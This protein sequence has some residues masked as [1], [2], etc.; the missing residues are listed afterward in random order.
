[1]VLSTL[2]M[3]IVIMGGMG[4][5]GL[6]KTVAGMETIYLDRV[7]PLEQLKVIADMYAVN[8]VDTTHQVRNGNFTWSQG[9]SNIEEAQRSIEE[10]WSEYLGTVLVDE[11]T[12][13]V[14]QIK[15]LMSKAD[16]EIEKLKAIMSARDQL[17][18]DEFTI[19]RLYPAIDPVSEK[20]AELTEVQLVVAKREFDKGN[21]VYSSLKGVTAVAVVVAVLLSATM[22]FFLVRAITLPLGRAITIADRIA[23]GNLDT[24]IMVTSNDETGQLLAALKTMSEKLFET[25]ADVRTA[26][27]NVATGA[28]QISAGNINLSQRTEEQASS[29]EET[30]SSM[31]EMTSTVKQNADNADQASQLAQTA[32]DQAEAGGNVVSQAVTAM[33]EINQ[34]SSKIADIISVV[35]EIAFQTNLLALNAAVEAARAGEQGR[36]FAVV[37]SEVRVL[38]GRSADAAKEI[39]NL[40][41]DSVNKVKVGSELVDKSGETL[42]EIVTGVKKVTD[43][44]FEI[45]AASQEQ[46]AGIDQVNKAI[47]QMDE[48]TQMNASLVEEAAAASKSMEDQARQLNG[49]MGFFKLSKDYE[50][51]MLKSAEQ[52]KI[53]F[54]SRLS[55]Q[56]HAVKQVQHQPALKSVARKTGTD[57][58]SW[59]DF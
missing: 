44:V 36:G 53:D 54:G 7:V 37:A 21:E 10:K 18:L 25:V 26:A 2:A 57:D 3:L 46:S 43:I 59:E 17:A 31:E 29:L 34:S 38:A 49:S 6:S 28:A 39:K 32:R 19:D 45:A 22:G 11:E 23:N 16:S 4:I 50:Q 13:L 42:K 41:E 20:F 52:K 47:T 56:G 9:I 40:I 8:V 55:T 48:M 12:R 35:E 58:G 30:A 33:G 27:G 14:G 5:N 1:M 51:A 24:N 15:P